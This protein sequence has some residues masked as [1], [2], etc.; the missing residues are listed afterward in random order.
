MEW[1]KI[2]RYPRYSIS[3]TGLLR[4]DK[5][6]KILK[7]G[8]DSNGYLSF[9]FHGKHKLIHRLVAEAFIPNP[10]NLP[11]I[12]HK[13]H[14]RTNNVVSNL[15]WVTRKE[16]ATHRCEENR[17]ASHGKVSVICVE[18][19]I[20]YPSMAKAAKSIGVNTSMLWKCIAG[21]SRT[22]GGFHW[23]VSL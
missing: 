16:N 6:G 2:D 8:K 10:L 11:E 12:H 21:R 19:N 3:D 5:T 17:K 20:T 4:N 7:P 22:A 14:N 13:D 23:K 9:I 15:E 1:K 18:T